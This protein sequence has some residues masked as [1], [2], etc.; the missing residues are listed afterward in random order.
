MTFAAP[1]PAK[2]KVLSVNYVLGSP[3]DCATRTP[4]ASPGQYCASD[5]L[6]KQMSLKILASSS[7]VK[8]VDYI[9]AFKA[10]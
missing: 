8:F 4:I 5:N 10:S 9:K 3:T 2:W 6:R 7:L 1:C